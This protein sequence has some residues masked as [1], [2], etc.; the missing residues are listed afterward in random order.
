[1]EK[2]FKI[3]K[4]IEIKDILYKHHDNHLYQGRDGTYYSILEDNYEWVG[5]KKDIE[6]YLKNCVTCV[7][8]IEKT[9]REK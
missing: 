4:K 2:K 8:N 3:P 7:K 1:M 5:I 9:K 6:L